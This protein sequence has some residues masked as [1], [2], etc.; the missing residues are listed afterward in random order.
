MSKDGGL[1]RFNP[2]TRQFDL[3]SSRIEY[4]NLR[5]IC[6][7]EGTL[8]LGFYSDGLL[9]YH[10]ETGSKRHYQSIDADTTTLSHQAVYKIFRSSDGIIYIGTLLGLDQ[11]LP[12]KDCFRRIRKSGHTGSRY[13]GRPHRIDLGGHLR[14]G[15]VLL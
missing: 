9:R 14:T 2:V 3:Y 6:D 10:P 11:Y 8:W 15:V 4:T 12:E 7:M 5:T 1:C 13:P